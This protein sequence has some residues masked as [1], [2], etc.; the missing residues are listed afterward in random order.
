MP[1]KTARERDMGLT[2]TSDL[3]Q[4]IDCYLLAWVAAPSPVLGRMTVE[5]FRPTLTSFR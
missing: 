5:F 2:A 1:I 3:L 4:K